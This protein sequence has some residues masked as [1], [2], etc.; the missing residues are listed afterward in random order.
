M[1]SHLARETG[2]STFT[3]V[4]SDQIRA[5]FEQIATELRNQ[6]LVGYTPQPANSAPGRFRTISVSLLARPDARARTRAG[7]IPA[8]GTRLASLSAVS[9]Q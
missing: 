5:A 1:L 3:I 2:A 4:R 6:Y 7:Y 8:S 9:A